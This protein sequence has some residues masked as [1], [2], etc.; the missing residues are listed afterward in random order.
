M[1]KINSVGVYKVY[2]ALLTQSGTADP[3]VIVLDNTLS[4][5]IVWTRTSQ[6]FYRGTLTGAFTANKTFFIVGQAIDNNNFTTS[7]GYQTTDLFQVITRNGGST[8][9]D[10]ILNS[11]SIEIRVY[12]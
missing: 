1:K 6:G 7:I 2:T 4:A 10:G 8:A 11:T 5:A 12:N 9:T 3:T